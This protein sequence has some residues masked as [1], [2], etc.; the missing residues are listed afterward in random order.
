MVPSSPRLPVE[1]VR[2]TLLTALS[3]GPVVLSAPTG[4]GKSTAVPRW[5]A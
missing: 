4:S 1:E 2:S 5:L 3:R